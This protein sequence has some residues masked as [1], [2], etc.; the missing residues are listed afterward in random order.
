MGLRGW[1]EGGEREGRDGMGGRK[2]GREGR[3]GEGKGGRWIEMNRCRR[4][5]MTGFGGWGVGLRFAG[6]KRA[7]VL[8]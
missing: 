7:G 1:G 8:F 4:D 5:S 3:K 6:E 2:G